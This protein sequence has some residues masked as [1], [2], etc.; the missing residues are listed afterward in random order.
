[1][2][3]NVREIWLCFK[4]NRNIRKLFRYYQTYSEKVQKCFIFTPTKQIQLISILF[5][6]ISLRICEIYCSRNPKLLIG[7]SEPEETNRHK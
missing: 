4:Q 5:S 7:N 2:L 3:S 6:A 1:M